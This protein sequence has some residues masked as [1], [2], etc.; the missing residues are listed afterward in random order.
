MKSFNKQ[1]TSNP[2]ANSRKQTLQAFSSHID[3]SSESL[4]A[5]VSSTHLNI[6][7]RDALKKTCAALGYGRA[8]VYVTL[9]L[10]SSLT[11]SDEKPIDRMRLMELIE[12][13]DPVC[14]VATDTEAARRCG[15][16]YHAPYET[17]MQTHLF[18]RPA[19]SFDKF[20][21]LLGSDEK[22][23][24]AWRCLRSLRFKH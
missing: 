6:A 20:E 16:A 22:R 2:Y 12:G 17:M 21:A 11:K 1:S 4:F 15:D 8:I 18:G 3:G 5:V 13:L 14:L 19:C 24:S 7:A 23:Q 10:P 9:D